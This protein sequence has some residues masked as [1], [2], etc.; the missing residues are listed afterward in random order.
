MVDL[1]HLRGA[2]ALELAAGLVPIVRP[3][4]LRLVWLSSAQFIIYEMA[5]SVFAVNESGDRIKRGDKVVLV[6]YKAQRKCYVVVRSR[7]GP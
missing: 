6:S 7:E 3:S 1:D 5:S 2:L 4:V